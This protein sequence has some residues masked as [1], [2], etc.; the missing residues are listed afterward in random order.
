MMT[1]PILLA[2]GL[3]INVTNDCAVFEKENNVTLESNVGVLNFESKMPSLRYGGDND[4]YENNDCY[5]NAYNLSPSNY[6]LLNSYQ[7]Q[8]EATLVCDGDIADMDFFYFKILSRSFVEIEIEAPL[9]YQPYTF[10]L[11]H[12]SYQFSNNHYSTDY[13]DV[14][15]VSYSSTSK[16][17]SGNIDPGTYFI[18]LNRMGQSSFYG[19]IDYEINLEV[20]CLTSNESYQIGDLYYTKNLQFAYWARDFVPVQHLGNFYK[21]I[22]YKYDTVSESEESGNF[23]MYELQALTSSDPFL[24]E[25]YYLWGDDVKMVFKEIIKAMIDGFFSDIQYDMTLTREVQITKNLFDNI[26]SVACFV[27]GIQVFSKTISTASTIIG[28]VWPIISSH[29]FNSFVPEVGMSDF[30]FAE[31][32]GYYYG[33]LTNSPMGEVIYLPVYATLTSETHTIPAKTDYYFTTKDTPEI[34][35][36]SDCG[37]WDNGTISTYNKGHSYLKGQFYTFINEQKVKISSISDSL[38]SYNLFSPL[39]GTFDIYF[40][41]GYEWLKFSHAASNYY[42]YFESNTTDDLIVE[43]FNSLVIGHSTIGRLYAYQ[44]NAT[45]ISNN[46]KVV[47]FNLSFST[48]SDIYFRIRG[49]DYGPRLNVNYGLGDIS[50]YLNHVHNHNNHYE[51]YNLYNHYAYCDCGHSTLQAHAVSQSFLL[52]DDPNYNG[53][54]GPYQTCLLCGGQAASGLIHGIGDVDAIT[55]NGSYITKDGI[56]VIADEDLDLFFNKEIV[57]YN[58]DGTRRTIYE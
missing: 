14:L 18:V 31:V 53:P 36:L 41:G 15:Y 35:Y 42:F 38:P 25:E 26:I 27:G 21:P 29:I 20:T 12:D 37:L 52:S 40:D 16:S 33:L 17:Y 24:I 30:Y 51:W 49:S 10:I 50:L 55:S 57:F 13:Q 28:F 3:T 4:S 39:G 46:N 23:A 58:L 1:I 43:V 8:I 48:S 56:I 34:I 19:N 6:Y 47:F 32:L 45:N 2:L 54:G 22:D 7:T 11:T 44:V 5:A 9:S